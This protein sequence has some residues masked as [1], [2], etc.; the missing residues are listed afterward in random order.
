MRRR[1]ALLAALGLTLAAGAA[2][3]PAAL[4]QETTPPVTTASLDPAAPGPGGTYGAPVDVT[5]SATD[6]DEGTDP[7][8]HTVTAEGFAWDVQE[9]DATAGDTV[10]WDFSGATHD[11]CIDDSPPEWSEAF[12]D[13]GDDE[14]LGDA[15]EGDTGGEKTFTT[16]GSYGYYCSLHE[17]SMRGTVNVAEGG[18]TP[19]SGVETSEYRVITDATPGELVQSVNGASEDPFETTFTVSEPGEHVVEYFSTDAEGNVEA[20][21]QVAFSIDPAGGGEPAVD[22]TVKPRTKR[23]KVNRPISLNARLA[24]GGG[25]ATEVQVCVK[26]KSRLVKVTGGRC[27]WLDELAGGAARTTKFTFK[28]KRAARGKRVRLRFRTTHTGGPTKTTTA[29]LKV[30]RR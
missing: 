27:W 25:P 7:E 18:G 26:A 13:C 4:A 9:V 21:K 6:P 14:V 1:A 29:T 23:A 3:A 30:A 12:G 16:P 17:P 28:P 8:T 5:L 11:I 19:G 10:E 20:T 15:R 22:L 24:N 2:G